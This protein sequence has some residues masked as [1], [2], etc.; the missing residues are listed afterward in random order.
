MH[1][2][3]DDLIK[4]DPIGDP[5]TVTA[6]RMGGIDRGAVGEQDGE[7]GPD[8]LDHGYWHHGHGNLQHDFGSAPLSLL[9]PCLS[10]P[11][12]RSLLVFNAL[13][14]D[15]G[16]WTSEAIYEAQTPG[17]YFVE[18]SNVMGAVNWSLAFE[19]F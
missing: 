12:C 19:P 17:A 15:A 9:E 3:R 7:L 11:Y 14:S 1:Q 6:Q 10:V 18:V 5:G 2:R 16:E 8:R 4:H 13:I